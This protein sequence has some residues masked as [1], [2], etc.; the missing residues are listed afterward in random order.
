MASSRRRQDLDGKLVGRP[1]LLQPTHP[2]LARTG[3]P[4]TFMLPMALKKMT[5][6]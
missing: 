4:L 6:W 3:S 1:R 2:P 5:R